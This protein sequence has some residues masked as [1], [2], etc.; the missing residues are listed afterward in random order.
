MPHEQEL[1]KKCAA[2]ACRSC[3]QVGLQPV[4]DLGM[5]PLTAA[6]LTAEQLGKPEP[7]YPLEVG[8]CP[9]CTL[10][11]VLQL[12]PPEA[13]FHSEYP[14]YSSFSPAFVAHARESA[15]SLIARR[16]LDC[17][18]LVVELASNDG[19]LLRHFVERGVPVLGIDPAPGPAR[20]AEKV[21]VP[22]LVEFFGAEMARRLRAGGKTADVVLAN[23]VIGHVA[24]LNGF[25]EGIKI[26]LKDS[27]VAVIEIPYA[28]NLIDQ[29]E[30]D[31]IYHEHLFYYT[32]TALD[33][34]FRRH[35]LYLNDVQMIPVHGGS[36]RL[37]VEHRE[38]VKPVV[39]QLLADERAKGMDK[40]AYYQSFT[41]RVHGIREPLRKLIAE[42]KAK[43]SRIVAYGAA[44]KGIVLLNYLGVGREQIEYVV[45]RNVHKQG[46]F[47]PGVHLPVK[48]PKQLLEDVPQYTL[49]LSWN[50]RDEVLQQQAEY[51][52]RGGKF[53]V[54][55]PV[56]QVV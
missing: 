17:N 8:F 24:D 36:F 34:M 2:A 39:K 30:F 10:L 18:S 7:K 49:L 5:M 27:G 35:G 20:E 19:Y 46:K 11:Q 16:K 32:A 40:F 23:N 3:G 9:R 13:V 4:L 48:D 28:K 22:T 1:G 42:L 25:V 38:D 52:A 15:L 29:C 53:I 43:G 31:T 51:R 41:Q 50:F 37:F 56:L 44:A 54:P 55:I 47:L 21:G 12:V 33:Q 14:Y 26:L 45:D 6:F